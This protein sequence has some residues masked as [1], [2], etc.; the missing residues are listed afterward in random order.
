M[1]IL[2]SVWYRIGLNTDEAK[3]A[4]DKVTFDTTFG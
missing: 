3:R 1:S 2:G 4:L